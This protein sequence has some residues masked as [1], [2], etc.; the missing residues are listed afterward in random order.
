MKGEYTNVLRSAGGWL[1]ETGLVKRLV[2]RLLA[3]RPICRAALLAERVKFGDVASLL[4]LT[5]S[6]ALLSLLILGFE[7]VFS[8]LN[9]KNK[10]A[11]PVSS[12]SVKTVKSDAVLSAESNHSKLS[13]V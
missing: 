8:K 5:L 13:F 6:G 12:L 11:R 2:L 4:A 1:L 3:Q 10:S 9:M 7:I